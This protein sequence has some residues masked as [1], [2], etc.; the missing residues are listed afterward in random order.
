MDD[1]MMLTKSL[2]EFRDERDWKRFH[3]PKDI[4]ISIC[5][6]SAELLEHFQWKD[7][8][9]CEQ[10][11]KDDKAIQEIKEEVADIAIYLLILC[12]DLG[13]NIVDI[14]KNKIEKNRAKYPVDKSKG[15][16][17]KYDRL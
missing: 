3:K 8:T 6:E 10:Y 5:L 14:V 13:F 15:R 9:D 4:A 11:L 16:Y 1:L 17:E 7:D 2:I 12:N